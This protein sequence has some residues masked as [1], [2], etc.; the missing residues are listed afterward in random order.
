M[1]KTHLIT[2]LKSK[3]YKDKYKFLYYHD[4]NKRGKNFWAFFALLEFGK[5]NNNN[6][7]NI[8]LLIW[9][10]KKNEL[11]LYNNIDDILEKVFKEKIDINNYLYK[12]LYKYKHRYQFIYLVDY[13][14]YGLY[15]D[16]DLLNVKINIE[17][18]KY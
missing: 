4:I 18:I 11:I 7:N 10:I 15:K 2:D 14:W 5:L 1:I 17:F 12:S 9:D 6:E 13:Y 16:I 8:P 3:I